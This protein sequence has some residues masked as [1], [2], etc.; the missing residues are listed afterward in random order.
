MASLTD[1]ELILSGMQNGSEKVQALL[2][3]A[4]IGYWTIPALLAIPLTFVAAA[5]SGIA[6]KT[7][8]DCELD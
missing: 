6:A 4:N 2:K 5:A 3:D 1:K 7:T 8:Y